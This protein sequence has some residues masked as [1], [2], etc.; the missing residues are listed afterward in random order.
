MCAARAT[1]FNQYLYK[2]P[3]SLENQRALLLRYLTSTCDERTCTMMSHSE[4]PRHDNQNINRSSCHHVIQVLND[5]TK[6]NHYHY[7]PPRSRSMK[8][9]YYTQHQSRSKRSII[10]LFPKSR[11]QNNDQFLHLSVM[12][13]NVPCPLKKAQ[14]QLNHQYFDLLTTAA[15]QKLATMRRSHQLLTNTSQ[16]IQ[17]QR[18]NRRE[19]ATTTKPM[20]PS[21]LR[22]LGSDKL[23]KVA[24]ETH[25][26]TFGSATV[27][28][29]D[30]FILTTL[31]KDYGCCLTCCHLV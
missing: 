10:I 25:Y 28:S 26:H 2:F 18:H 13:K 9:S 12:G 30:N 3:L 5:A 19:Q 1:L 22:W 4:R 8:T 27:Q 6:V 31:N 29:S 14:C 21:T 24:S 11:P 17:P 16:F 20:L 7:T 23:F 15:A